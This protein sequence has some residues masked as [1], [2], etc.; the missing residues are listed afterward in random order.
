MDVGIEH[1]TIAKAGLEL[2]I[3]CLHLLSALLQGCIHVRFYLVQTPFSKW[4]G[5]LLLFYDFLRS[6]ARVSV[7]VWVCACEL[8]R[9]RGQKKGRIHG[10]GVAGAL[11]NTCL[12]LCARNPILSESS[13]CS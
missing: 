9:F 8:C 13:K 1:Y 10:A 2:L 11:V 4:T 6:C 3:L 7:C 12:S 5:L